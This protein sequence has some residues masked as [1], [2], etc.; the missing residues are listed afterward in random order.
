M[1]HLG[2]ELDSGL[3][4]GF[5]GARARGL[6]EFGAGVKPIHPNDRPRTFLPKRPPTL[7]YQ[8]LQMA[9]TAA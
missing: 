3:P 7:P 9:S 2:R 1:G 4:M 5:D 6:A 8:P